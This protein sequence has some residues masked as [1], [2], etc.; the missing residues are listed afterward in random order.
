MTEKEGGDSSLEDELREEQVLIEWIQE[1]ESS[2]IIE[3]AAFW[4]YNAYSIAKPVEDNDPSSFYVREV[5]F[6]IRNL[7]TN[8]NIIIFTE[9]R[10]A[11]WIKFIR[12][13]PQ[14]I[15]PLITNHI[16]FILKKLS[17]S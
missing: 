16:V 9:E 7:E 13:I 1:N 10:F 12:N 3:V 17:L 14:T 6:I 15:E 11:S 8:F 2:I 4:I 5:Q